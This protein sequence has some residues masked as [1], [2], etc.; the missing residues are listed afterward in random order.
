MVEK[1]AESLRKG[2]SCKKVHRLIKNFFT[3]NVSLLLLRGPATDLKRI[4]TIAD[5]IPNS[6]S[7]EYLIPAD[8]EADTTGYAIQLIVEGTGQYQY[9]TQFGI[10]NDAIPSDDSDD[11]DDDDDE[12]NGT[13]AITSYAHPANGTSTV[14]VLSVTPSVS[15]TAVPTA[16]NTH[17]PVYDA[18]VDVD[19]YDADAEI[20][21]IDDADVEAAV[22]VDVDAYDVD[23]EIVPVDDSGLDALNTTDNSTADF[24]PFLGA[25]APMQQIFS[26]AALVAVAGI[27]SVFAL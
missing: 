11:D 25:A 1:S 6:G 2:E 19:A 9:S 4:D 16:V 7:Y 24:V 8:L 15:S 26:T 3:D 5:N 27:V 18:D 13:D 12:Y 20:V 21:P 23:A 17:E 10:E 14:T 22:D